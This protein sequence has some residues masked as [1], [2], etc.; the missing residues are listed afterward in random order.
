MANR[1]DPISINVYLA[2][3]LCILTSYTPPWLDWCI[4]AAVLALNIKICAD[5]QWSV[6]N[7]F[8]FIILCQV[9]SLMSGFA[10]DHDPLDGEWGGASEPNEWL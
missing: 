6:P 5:R 8:V 9:M 10:T 7:W 1:N 3:F 2:I 4:S